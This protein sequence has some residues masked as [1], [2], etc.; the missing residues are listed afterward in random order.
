MPSLELVVF[1]LAAAHNSE[2]WPS[3]LYDQ[4]SS[5]FLGD[6]KFLFVYLFLHGKPCQYTNRSQD[7]RQSRPPINN[8][9]DETVVQQTDNNKERCATTFLRLGLTFASI[10]F[11][12]GS[13]VHDC[14]NLKCKQTIS[15]DLCSQRRTFVF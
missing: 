13:S 11:V 6:S 12:R 15:R 4:D 3:C 2:N 14:V 7:P 8:S 5:A 1:V 9:R 10:K